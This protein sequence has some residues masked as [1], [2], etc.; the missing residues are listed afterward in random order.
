MEIIQAV[1]SL[2]EE[3]ERISQAHE[4][5]TDTDVRES[6]HLALNYY[7]VWGRKDTRMPRSFGMFSREGN[8]LVSDAVRRFL[9]AVGESEALSD[10]PCGQSR[11]DVLQA[12]GVRTVGGMMY[13]EFIGHRDSPL[14]PEPLPEQMFLESEYDGESE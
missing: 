12:I 13:D 3:L 10:I 6:L 14:P 11:L 8:V 7:F 2:L 5:V 1:V 4:E 9:D